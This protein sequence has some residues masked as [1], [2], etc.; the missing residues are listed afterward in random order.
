MKCPDLF[1][2]ESLDVQGDYISRGNC[3]EICCRDAGIDV[4]RVGQRVV[5]LPMMEADVGD[6]IGRSVDAVAPVLC[7]ALR[8]GSKLHVNV[9]TRLPNADDFDSIGLVGKFC[10]V[11]KHVGCRRMMERSG[12]SVGH[13]AAN[14]TIHDVLVVT[15]LRIV[16]GI[17]ALVVGREFNHRSRGIG[18]NHG[19]LGHDVWIEVGSVVALAGSKEKE[20]QQKQTLSN[21]PV[22]GENFYLFHGFVLFNVQCSM[23]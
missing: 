12:L 11:T 2:L 18:S 23:I 14:G 21:S 6:S 5:V 15:L 3:F 10:G 9:S 7:A 1:A 4:L 22:K 13:K 19:E 20:E 8:E 17:C 16:E